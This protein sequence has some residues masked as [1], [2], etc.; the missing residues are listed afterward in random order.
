[1]NKNGPVIV[2]EDDED[3]QAML[4]EIFKNLAYKN[5]VVFFKDGHKALEYL[6]KTEVIPFLILSDINMPRIN[7]L[8]L[9]NEIFINE[10]LH[11]KCIPYLFFTTNSTKKSVIE[12]YELAVQG[13]FVKPA[14][15]TTMENTIKKIMEYWKVCIAPNEFS[16]N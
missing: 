15:F 3:D 5:K 12:A 13:F 9:R 14:N 10:E 7:G 8:E 16:T 6:N 1:M 11:L 4:E 2:I